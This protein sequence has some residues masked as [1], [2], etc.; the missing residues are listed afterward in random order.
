MKFLIGDPNFQI[1]AATIKNRVLLPIMD[2][3]VKSQKSNL[4][5]PEAMVKTL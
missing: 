1:R 4:N 5:T 2:A 3:S